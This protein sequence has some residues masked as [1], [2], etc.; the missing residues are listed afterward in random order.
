MAT[1]L[2][3]GQL[4]LALPQGHSCW[5][6]ALIGAPGEWGREDVGIHLQRG[7][8][9]GGEGDTLLELDRNLEN[10]IQTIGFPGQIGLTLGCFK[11]LFQHQYSIS[12]LF[13]LRKITLCYFKQQSPSDDV[14]QAVVRRSN[15]MPLACS[16]CEVLEN[17]LCHWAIS[18]EATQ[19]LKSDS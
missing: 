8:P 12:F 17:H 4:T 3:K 1:I 11:G 6:P 19:D 7:F 15:E 13:S 2:W 18:P 14:H 16:H 10:S 9:I 5:E